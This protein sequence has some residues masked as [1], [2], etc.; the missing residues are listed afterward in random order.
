MPARGTLRRAI[1]LSALLLGSAAA[2]GAQETPGEALPVQDFTLENGLRLLILPKTGA[3]TVSFVVQY[4]IGSVNERPGV[5]GIA[6]L[7]EHLFFKGT[8]SIG[9]RDYGREA[10]LLEEMDLLNDTVLMV[11]EAESPDSL[12][13]G[14]LNRR[15]HSLEKRASELVVSNEFDAILTENGARSLNAMTTT[16]STTYFVELPSN[17]AELWFILESDRMRNPVFREF[18]TERDVVAEERRLRLETN[19]SGLLYE[20]LLAEAFKVHPYGRPVVGSMEDIQGLSRRDVQDYFRRFYGPNNA[21]VS[22][23]GDVDPGQILRWARR[24]LGSIPAG[25]PAPRV[26]VQE[27]EQTGERRVEIVLDAEPMLQVGWRV[28]SALHEDAPTLAMLA[29]LLTGGRSSRLYHRLV[30]QDRTATNVVSGTAPGNR[31]PGLF[32]IDAIPRSPHTPMEVEEA[33]YE[34]LQRLKNEPPGEMELQRVR[35]QLEASNVRR[36]SSNLG[37]ALQLAESTSLYG[38]WESTFAFTR[39]MVA[40]T[41]AD[42]QTVVRRYF[43]PDHRTVAVLRKSADGEGGSP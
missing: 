39:S 27:P 18:Y 33:I 17:R 3:P 35:N 41:P 5:T 25:P 8:T 14:A 1:L 38:D 23:V 26:M 36:L 15:I 31:Y 7:L 28:P 20:A 22:I 30:L 29:S 37:L 19:P 2:L 43:R 40:V 21:V 34:E 4:P 6:H 42:V 16:E 10:P 13:I 9:A 11:R 32:H 12:R 24:Y